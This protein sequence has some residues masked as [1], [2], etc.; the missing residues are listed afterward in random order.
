[1]YAVIRH[2]TTNE[3]SYVYPERFAT[4][5]EAVSWAAERTPLQPTEKVHYSVA[6]IEAEIVMQTAA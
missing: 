5:S 6:R 1:M 4:K 3:S 2:Y